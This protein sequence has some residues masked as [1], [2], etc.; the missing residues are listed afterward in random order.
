MLGWLCERMVLGN[1]QFGEWRK[2]PKPLGLFLRST[3]MRLWWSVR[4]YIP[5]RM[6]SDQHRS[7][8]ISAGG[9]ECVPGL[10]TVPCQ[11]PVSETLLFRFAKLA[12]GDHGSANQQP[13][14]VVAQRFGSIIRIQVTSS[15]IS[16]IEDHTNASKRYERI[17][18]YRWTSVEKPHS[19]K[20]ELLFQRKQIP[21]FL[22]KGVFP[23]LYL[24]CTEN[25]LR[26]VHDLCHLKVMTSVACMKR[27]VKIDFSPRRTEFIW[28]K[29]MTKN[30]QH[31]TSVTDRQPVSLRTTAF[32]H[33]S[34]WSNTHTFSCPHCWVWERSVISSDMTLQMFSA[35]V[36]FQ[37]NAF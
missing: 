18:S 6:C 24:M 16:E 25:C 23:R 9:S 3:Y 29:N 26:K 37:F 11:S 8:W 10:L 7:L 12:E 19:C 35:T 1:G 33:L 5:T 31:E 14:S 2:K 21:L 27:V 34:S 15:A 32:M 17:F 20:P 13:R 28:L 22:I 36:G 4:S 30:Y